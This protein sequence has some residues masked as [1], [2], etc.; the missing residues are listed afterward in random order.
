MD[1][2]NVSRDVFSACNFKLAVPE[3]SYLGHSTGPYRKA[4]KVLKFY[5]IL[6]SYNC[7]QVKVGKL[8]SFTLF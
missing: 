2:V 6:H 3:W 1:T 7:C 5:I 8:V 4:F